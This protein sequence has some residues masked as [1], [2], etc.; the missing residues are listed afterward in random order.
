[1]NAT[2][3]IEKFGLQPHPEGGMFRE[4]YRC[5]LRMNTSSGEDSRSVSTAILFMLKDGDFS[6]FH[7]IS[8]DELWHYHLGKGA[9][10]YCINE[11]GVLSQFRLSAD[12]NPD[13]QLQIVIPANTWFAA[14]LIEPNDFLLTGCTVAPGFDFKDFTLAE[15]NTLI[16]QFPQHRQLISRLTRV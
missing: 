7:K 15:R 5:N 16:A 10:I 14:E 12:E 13:S 2:T 11:K 6:A 4:T 9:Y 8:S 3:I 1:M